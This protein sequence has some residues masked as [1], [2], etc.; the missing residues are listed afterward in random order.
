MVHF[1]SIF[2]SLKYGLAIH[3]PP[4]SATENPGF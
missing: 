4:K 3:L 1:P 2:Q